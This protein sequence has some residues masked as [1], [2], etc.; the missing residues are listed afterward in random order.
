MRNGYKAQSK[1]IDDMT[2]RKFNR[3]FAPNRTQNDWISSDKKSVDNY[4][5]DSLCSFI[6]TNSLWHD[7]CITMLNIFKK[8]IIYQ[9]ILISLY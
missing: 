1:F 9:V 7:V 2:I 6:V 5:N 8:I 4:T 3:D